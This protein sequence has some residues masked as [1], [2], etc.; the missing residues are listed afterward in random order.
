M[1]Q[2]ELPLGTLPIKAVFLSNGLLALVRYAASPIILDQPEKS[3]V[4]AEIYSDTMVL[5]LGEEKE[6]VSFQTMLDWKNSPLLLS[7]LKQQNIQ[8]PF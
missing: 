1:Q 8:F 2:V 6:E 7:W 5:S 4:S 3:G